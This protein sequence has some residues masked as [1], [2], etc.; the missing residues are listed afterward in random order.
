M[1]KLYLDTCIFLDYWWDRK[2]NLRPLG[3]FAFQ[4]INRAI[5][6]EFIIVISEDTLTELSNVLEKNRRHIKKTLLNGLMTK[7]KIETITATKAQ[8]KETKRISKKYGV[9]SLD[10][11]HA[12][13]ARDMGI[14]LVSRDNHMFYL[15]EKEEFETFKLKKPEEI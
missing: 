13:L 9:P 12:I 6:C 5:E 3:E 11:Q 1:R 15:A 2:E 10:A 14:T 7:N 8:E 4:L